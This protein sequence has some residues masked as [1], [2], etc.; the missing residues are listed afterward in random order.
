MGNREI[1]QKAISELVTGDYML[2]D[3]PYF[4]NVGDVMIWQSALD[5]LEK[6]PHRCLYAS[7]IEN[8]N[9]PQLSSDVIIL[10][11]GGGNFGDL[12]VRHQE[13]RHR[14][15][16]DFPENKIIQ[17]PQSVFFKDEKY[18]RQ[19][20]ETFEKHRGE[21]VVCLRDEKS[22]TIIDSYYHNV[23][24]LLLPDMALSFD[25]RTYCD[26]H[27]IKIEKGQGTLY[28][29]RH[30]S[31]AVPGDGGNKATGVTVA[32][33]PS[34][35]STP[36]AM[37]LFWLARK[38]VRLVGGDV[39]RF[40]DRCWSKWLKDVML[41]SGIKFIARYEKICSTRLHAAVLGML[42]GKKVEM[43]DNS[44]GKCKGVYDLWLREES[45]IEMK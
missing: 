13:F 14:V 45:N 23:K 34:M 2:L 36:R 3:L 22:K 37:Y 29:E 18:M 16:N 10:F 8:Y 35:C 38:A 31:E 40:T 20:I 43:I 33:W 4:A 27:S 41:K 6:V 28:V 39:D 32:D 7:S 19:D 30:D 21:I 11:M 44:Y 17:L 42:L 24:T 9:R 12:W 15:M 5:L 25:V 1:L 26:K